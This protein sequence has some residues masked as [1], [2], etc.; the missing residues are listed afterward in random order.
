MTKVYSA[1]DLQALSA[2]A[3][4]SPRQRAHLNIHAELDDP[5]QRLF[6]ASQPNTYMR[7]HKHPQGNKDEL[8]LVLQGQ[9]DLLIFDDNGQVLQRTPLHADGA[10]A[11]ETPPN[12]I[13]GY[14]CMQAD[15][16]ALEVKQG[17]YIPGAPEDFAHWAPEEGSE[18]AAAFVEWMRQARPGDKVS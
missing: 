17:P 6:I 9:M 11:A 14:V 12:T 2:Q 8:F 18:G 4:A 7:P 16:V 1:A 5:V 3:L 10:R 15:S 13:H